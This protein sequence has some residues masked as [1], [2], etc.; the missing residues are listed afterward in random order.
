MC[1][2]LVPVFDTSYRI[3][4]GGNENKGVKGVRSFKFILLSLLYLLLPLL[5]LSL[6]LQATENITWSTL[7]SRTAGIYAFV[8]Y[9]LQFI[10]TA[11][12]R[13]LERLIAQDKR[14]VLHML[15]AI[16]V[17]VIVLIHTGFGNEKYI[18]KIQAGLGGTADMVLLW[19][20][21]FSGL[22]FSN[23]FI[24]FL[25][26]LKPFRDKIA[27]VLT[28]T[29][30]RC[31]LLHYAMPAGMV[32]LIAHVVLIPEQGLIVFKAGMAMI[33]AG[34]LF[35]FLYYKIRVSQ[36]LEKDPWKVNK[37]I[38]ESDSVF[39]MLFDPPPGRKIKHRAGQ[40]CYIRPLDRSMPSQSHPFTISSPPKDR[41]LSIT[42]KQLGDFTA[43]IKE[44]KCGSSVSIDGP[45]GD[46]SYDRVLS[47]RTLIFIAGGIGV[48]P[49]LSMLGDL[50]IQDPK[51][52]VILL[53]GVRS[54]KDLIRLNEIQ[55]IG[56]Q[57]PL[58][59]FEPVLSREPVWAGLRG[60]I[61]KIM[62]DQ[63]LKRHGV[64]MDALN[65][66]ACE[67]FICGPGPMTMDILQV[68]KETKIPSCTI[69]TEQFSF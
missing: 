15:F 41:Q 19:A 1:A 57:M 67:F 5:L 17:L 32:L 63:V 51:R 7:V 10:I 58:F 54:K 39:T 34:P 46:F 33:G 61:D 55:A 31:L 40:F 43:K 62:L 35:V 8:W 50:S 49:M 14:L 22:F 64:N 65:Q 18:S 3:L 29:H 44:I 20:T 13:L 25:P 59:V 16:G 53:W 60:R 4:H 12:I 30:E 11:R 6:F 56:K 28:L 69:H 37:V 36:M 47:G 45:Y 9:A 68:L 38:F 52:K 48:T 23:Y 2:V 27:A 24:R 21:L 26:V 66:A 42:V